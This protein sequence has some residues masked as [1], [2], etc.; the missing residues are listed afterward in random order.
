MELL[1]MRA[2]I[3]EE[4]RT[5][6][7]RFQNGINLEIID[8]VKLLPYRDLNELVQ[9]CSRVD[10]Q[11][12]RK[13]FRKDFNHYYSKNFKNEGSSSKPYFKEQEKEKSSLKAPSK[14]SKSSDIN[15]FK[16][17]GKGHISSQCPTKKTMILR[18]QYHYSSLDEATS[19]SSTSSSEGEVIDLEEEILPCSGDLLM[20]RRLPN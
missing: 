10:H 4:E 6:I 11:L 15:Y 1:M 19:S 9:L 8:K 2:G 20:V 17:L 3:R 5:T 7:S 14:E 12:K 16:C 13:S 18:G